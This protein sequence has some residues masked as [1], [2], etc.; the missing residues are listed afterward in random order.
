MTR[1]SLGEGVSFHPV[2]YFHAEVKFWTPRADIP[3]HSQYLPW[4]RLSK[5]QEGTVLGI[6]SLVWG[7]GTLESVESYCYS[8]LPPL[9]NFTHLNAWSWGLPGRE[10]AVLKCGIILL[11]IN[12]WEIA[13]NLLGCP[14]LWARRPKAGRVQ[15]WPGTPAGSNP[16]AKSRA[17]PLSLVALLPNSELSAYK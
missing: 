5:G 12:C 15:I 1:A 2:I 17:L 13:S 16:R 7:S 14:P 10:W 6:V 4:G 11:A 8:S 9:K 3:V